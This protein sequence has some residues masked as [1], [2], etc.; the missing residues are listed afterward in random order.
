MLVKVH[1]DGELGEVGVVIRVSTTIYRLRTLLQTLA[2]NSKA[3]LPFV[4]AR[5]VVR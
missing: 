2:G 3:G 1:H 4:S 5:K